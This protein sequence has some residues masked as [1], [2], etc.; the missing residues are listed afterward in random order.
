MTETTTTPATAPVLERS[1]VIAYI[2]DHYPDEKVIIPDGLDYA[3]IGIGFSHGQPFACY[4]T[5]KVLKCLI[6]DDGMT[7]LE[8]REYFEFNIQDAYIG[9][10]MPVF[11]DIVDAGEIYGRS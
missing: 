2:E 7:L 8:A 9:E 5:A 10:G 3:F 11:I 4:D 6:D 1:A